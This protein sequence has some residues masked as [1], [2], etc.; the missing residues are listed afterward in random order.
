MNQSGHM[1]HTQSRRSF[2]L[3]LGSFV[4]GILYL[5]VGFMSYNDPL[6]GVSIVAYLFVFSAILRGASY[7][8]RHFKSKQRGDLEDNLF[9]TLGIIDILAGIF[10]ALNL[11]TVILSLPIFFAVWFITSSIMMLFAAGRIRLHNYNQYM[12]VTILSILG[13]IAGLMLLSNPLASVLTIDMFVAFYFLTS[14]ISHIAQ[15]F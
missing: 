9:L 12:L 13:I 2:S 15:A 7:L 5:I 1:N 8:M 3:D 10:L 14:G 11:R 4:V 6:E